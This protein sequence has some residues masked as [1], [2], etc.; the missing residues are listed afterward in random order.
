[1][2]YSLL[3][4]HIDGKW[5]YHRKTFTTRAE[6]EEMLPRWIWWDPDRP[7]KIIEHETPLPAATLYTTDCRTFRD[8]SGEINVTIDSK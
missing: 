6:A 7:K 5:W 4:Q 1:M 2:F 3:E 8:V